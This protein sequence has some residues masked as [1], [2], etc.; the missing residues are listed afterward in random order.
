ME[1]DNKKKA[2]EYKTRAKVD[3]V[4]GAVFAGLYVTA[5]ILRSRG[6]YISSPKIVK[7][8]VA[9]AP[10]YFGFTGASGIISLGNY[11]LYKH[12]SKKTDNAVEMK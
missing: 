2:E 3:L 6:I 8:F 5:E 1:K 9:S 10:W 12:Y 11:C 7:E 4:F